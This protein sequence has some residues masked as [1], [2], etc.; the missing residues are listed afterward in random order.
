MSLTPDSRFR[1]RSRSD[2]W[3][4]QP[5]SPGSVPRTASALGS[6]ASNDSHGT[7]KSKVPPVVETANESDSGRGDV[8][9]QRGLEHLNSTIAASVAAAARCRAGCVPLLISYD[10]YRNPEYDE[11]EHD[12]LVE[13]ERCGRC[14][15]SGLTFFIRIFNL[16]VVGV[17]VAILALAIWM[18]NLPSSGGV[19]QQLQGAYMHLVLLALGFVYM[20]LP[21]AMGPTFC[22]TPN[23]A[24]ACF[25][26]SGR[27]KAMLIT[28]ILKVALAF[29]AFAI[30]T[31][32]VLIAYAAPVREA[33][34]SD[35]IFLAM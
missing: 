3:W 10:M 19:T 29:N 28:S 25:G 13:S 22:L 9:N 18:I 12:E 15:I 23:L 27:E 32:G 30:G 31:L 2:E 7:V 35:T 1:S 16:V 33:L 17:G 4:D 6:T 24:C 20:C 5:P 11:L 21:C 8:E 34:L 26:E 14:I